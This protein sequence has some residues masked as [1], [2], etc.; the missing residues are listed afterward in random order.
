[1]DSI[2]GLYQLQEIDSKID[3]LKS[4]LIDVQDKLSDR[5]ELIDIKIDIKTIKSNLTDAEVKLRLTQ[6]KIDD[7]QQRIDDWRILNSVNGMSP[8]LDHVESRP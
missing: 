1:M 7:V 2:K 4:I 6:T 8:T 5:S 3:K